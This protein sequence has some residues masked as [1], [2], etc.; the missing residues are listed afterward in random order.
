MSQAARWMR[1]GYLGALVSSLLLFCGCALFNQAPTA[2]ITATPLAGPSPL[3][4]TFDASESVDPDG[5]IRTYA[6]DFG[7]AGATSSEAIAHHTFLALTEAKVYTVTLRVTDAGGAS[8]ETVQTIE[9]QPS[10]G[11]TGGAGAPVARISVDRFIGMT[12]LAVL[13][14]GRASTAGT[15]TVTAYRWDFGDGATSNGA[16]VR[17]TYTPAATEE[18]TATLFVWNSDG[19]LDTEQVRI[20]VIVPEGTTSGD[21]PIAEFAMSDPLVLYHSPSPASTPSLY[22]VSFDPRG[23][24]ADAGHSIDYYAWDFGD[25]KTLVETSDLEVV[26]IYELTSPSRTF[27]VRLYV[28]DDQGLEG[29]QIVNL[30]L[31]Q[32]TD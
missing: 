8:D 30:T 17:H 6:W 7:D 14:D 12:P 26:H 20:I 3:V 11:G 31:A 29:S 1:V 2:V 28:Y 18:F 27:V 24:S 21:D 19:A 5:E 9:V 16:E 10:S 15:G 32:P 22:E 23:S 4:V 13:F 25:G